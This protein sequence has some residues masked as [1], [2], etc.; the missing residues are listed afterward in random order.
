[1][2]Q[3]TTIRAIRNVVERP[4]A[5]YGAFD[6]ESLV[7]AGLE[8]TGIEEIGLARQLDPDVVALAIESGDDWPTR[9]SEVIEQR[10]E[11]LP[12]LRKLHATTY[13]RYEFP[14]HITDV[15]PAGSVWSFRPFELVVRFQNRSDEP[16]VAVRVQVSWAGEPFRVEQVI[17]DVRDDAVTVIFDDEHALPVGPA[18]FHVTLYRGDGAASKFARTVYVLP[19]NP[20]SLQLAPAGARVTGTW[21]A[22][23]DYRPDS[24][25]F[26]TEIELTIAN[27]DAATVSMNRPVGW[28]FWD[29]DVGTG[30]LV[31]GGAFDWPSNIV[32]AGYSTWRGFVSFTS[33]R[34]SGIFG[35]Y[36]RKEDLAISLTMTAADGR[37]LNGR[38]TARVMLSYGVNIIKVGDFG[39]SEHVDLYDAVDALRQI[40]ERRDITLRGVDRRRITAAEAGGYTMLDSETEF[41]D[42][43]E[44]W[45]VPNNFIDIFVV[46]QFNWGGFNGYA[47]GEPGPAAKGGRT[48]GVA[49]DRT[50][51]IDASGTDRLNVTTLSQ[52]IGHEVGHY[53]GLPHQ[54]TAN[55]LMRGNTGD[56]GPDL[57]Y[58]QYRRMFPHGY[59]FYE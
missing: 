29:G 46:R 33:P 22:R 9:I 45:S 32:V 18:R 19:A 34:G 12:G 37:S 8:R 2:V 17:G 6:S 11:L 1:M 56:R 26:L 38:I 48:D 4:P 20:L 53:L 50:G 41:R 31:E 16:V 13:G 35:V 57:D 43:L 55:N 42:M 15:E 52:L 28:Q 54:E 36:D 14:L 7:L 5:A 59:M 40:Y 58:D 3:Q 27:G 25:T 23:G 21:S 24:D 47:G 49:A 51:Y 44:D 10:P 39:A 30:T